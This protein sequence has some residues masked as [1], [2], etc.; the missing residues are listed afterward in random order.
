MP[1]GD[2]LGFIDALLARP[3]IHM[4]EIGREWPTARSRPAWM[5]TAYFKDKEAL[6]V[7]VVSPDNGPSALVVQPP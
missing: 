1:I 4:P 7:K 6:W 3:G 2:P 5:H